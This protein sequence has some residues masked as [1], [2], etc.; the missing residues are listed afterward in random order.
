MKHVDFP[1]S[2]AVFTAEGCT[3]LPAHKTVDNTIISAWEPSN[4][5]IDEIVH[6]GLVFVGVQA[7]QPPMWVT[8]LSPFAEKPPE[9]PGS[10]EVF[11]AINEDGTFLPWTCAFRQKD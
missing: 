9:A 5:E 8:G 1:Q 4:R 11:I 7:I 3:D 10:K 6:T 2:N